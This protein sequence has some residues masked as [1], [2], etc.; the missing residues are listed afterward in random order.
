MAA[1]ETI[2]TGQNMTAIESQAAIGTL[3]LGAREQ[4]RD[5][6]AVPGHGV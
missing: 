5:R 4:N 2:T 1:T 3:S 6:D